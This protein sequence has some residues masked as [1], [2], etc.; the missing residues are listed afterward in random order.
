MIFRIPGNPRLVYRPQKIEIDGEHRYIATINIFHLAPENEQKKELLVST[1]SL[2]YDTKFPEKF[3]KYCDDMLRKKYS[4][5]LTIRANIE[6]II[7]DMP[8][9]LP[10]V[11]EPGP[12]WIDEGTGGYVV[13]VYLVDV[14]SGT[15]CKEES[16]V[17]DTLSLEYNPESP[18][19]FVASCERMIR[20]REGMLDNVEDILRKK[21]VE[22]QGQK[23]DL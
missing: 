4:E 12:I 22:R 5:L 16:C 17:V 23:A 8:K 21:M 13:S 6:K 1:F 20:I 9:N 10:F 15:A 11:C 19:K 18:E 7:N 3:L 2:E 14:L